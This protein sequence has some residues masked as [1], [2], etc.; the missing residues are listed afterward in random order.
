MIESTMYLRLHAN[1]NVSKLTVLRERFSLL[2]LIVLLLEL[3]ANNTTLLI[4]LFL[5]LFNKELAIFKNYWHP[6]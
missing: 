4:R 3:S 2:L 1:V 5:F 6:V